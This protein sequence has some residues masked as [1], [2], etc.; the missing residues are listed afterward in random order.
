M[1]AAAPNTPETQDALKKH[2]GGLARTFGIGKAFAGP[3]GGVVAAVGYIG[4]KVGWETGTRLVVATKAA[5]KG[6][7][8]AAEAPHDT[9][10]GPSGPE[11]TARETVSPGCPNTSY[12]KRTTP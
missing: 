6:K 11:R 9:Q 5:A 2:R 1:V 4:V 3:V 10:T 8:K 12:A 7:D